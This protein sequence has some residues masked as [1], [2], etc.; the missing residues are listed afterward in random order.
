MV[1]YEYPPLPP[2][3][4][5]QTVF[6]KPDPA[7]PLP[8]ILT[9]MLYTFDGTCHCTTEP[10]YVKDA[11]NG[12]WQLLSDVLLTADVDKPGQAVAEVAPVGQ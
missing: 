3:C 11:L 8:H 12:G 9:E 1:P 2:G 6:A 10:V 5:T 7:P 4:P